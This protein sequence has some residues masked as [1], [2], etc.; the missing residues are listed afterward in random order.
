MSQQLLEAVKRFPSLKN[1]C[2]S[3]PQLVKAVKFSTAS[4]WAIWNW[5][6]TL[7]KQKDWK[8]MPKSRSCWYLDE[9]SMPRS[10]R[11]LRSILFHLMS[12][13]IDAQIVGDVTVQ[14]HFHHF[15][16]RIAISHD[17]THW[18]EALQVYKLFALSHKHISCRNTRWHIL[19]RRHTNVTSASLASTHQVLWY[20]QMRTHM[21]E[22]S[23][24]CS[25]YKYTCT[26][27][28]NLHTQKWHTL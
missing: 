22:K 28:A 25:Q 3:R 4:K 14:L 21:G 10:I 16:R 12:L 9:R 17:D 20:I 19:A 24:K 27:V 5:W 26:Q 1:N 13:Q 8:G 23:Y 18:Q 7:L 2:V 11:L 6:G 15:L